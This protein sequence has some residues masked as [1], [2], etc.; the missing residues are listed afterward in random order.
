M[1]TL[2]DNVLLALATAA[3]LGTSAESLCAP[4]DP[5]AA[6]APHMT[7]RFRDLNLSDAR[8][9]EKLYLRIRLAAKMVCNE[10]SSSSDGSRMSHWTRCFNATIDDAVVRINRP[11][12]TALHN[13]KTKESKG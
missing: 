3:F 13:S 9:V 5:L 8:D 6:T 4:A 10:A 12:L 11:T 2:R 1:T 7:I